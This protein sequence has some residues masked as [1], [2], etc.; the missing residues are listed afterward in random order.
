MR[1]R[2]T[3]GFAIIFVVTSKDMDYHSPT[4]A[5]SGTAAPLHGHEEL[6]LA[7]LAEMEDLIHE[8]DEVLAR[9]A[10]RAARVCDAPIGLVSMM[11]A[12]AQWAVGAHGLSSFRVPRCDT[13]CAHTI[14]QPDVL[15]VE[16]AALDARF[17]QLPGVLD[18]PWVRFYA[19]APIFD[20]VGLPLGTVCVID[21]RP[22][23]L[24]FSALYALRNVAALAS[25]LLQARHRLAQ[26]ES[27]HAPESELVPHRSRL[28]GLN[29]EI[30]AADRPQA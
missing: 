11:E 19:G 24:S 17:R 30:L 1:V 13:I 26:A 25:S 18:A 2:N 4:F 9:L 28:A 8:G 5:S 22:R 23:D 7:S 6:R 15:V 29:E 16:D 20:G 3:T 21:P 14:L 10:E 12:D 27:H